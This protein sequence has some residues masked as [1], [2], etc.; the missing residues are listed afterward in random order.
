MNTTKIRGFTLLEL[1][2][3]VAVA[4]ILVTIGVPSFQSMVL[5]NRTRS[6]VVSLLEAVQTARADAIAQTTPV[7]VCG[8]STGQSCDGKWSSGWLVFKNPTGATSGTVSSSQIVATQQR[9]PSATALSAH[10]ASTTYIDYQ[11]S[12]L[13]NTDGYFTVCAGSNV[14]D[15]RSVI[16]SPTGSARIAQTTDTG[17]ALS[18]P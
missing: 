17:T 4:S 14:S 5:Q 8:S 7:T 2:V 16:I 3:T 10:L 15:A 1:M 11:P 13:S 6:A 9:L 12:G 18:C